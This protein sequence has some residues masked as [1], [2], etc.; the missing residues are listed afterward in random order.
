[1]YCYSL[2]FNSCFYSETKTAV[3]DPDAEGIKY[4]D[5]REDGEN[6]SID[7]DEETK[8]DVDEDSDKDS[9]ED[10]GALHI[11]RVN[12]RSGTRE[13]ERARLRVCVEITHPELKLP[14]YRTWT[15]TAL[16]TPPVVFVSVIKGTVYHAGFGSCCLQTHS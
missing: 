1:M 10:D 15:G 3:T 11:N 14:V 2:H 8:S 7:R 13:N 4:I 9:A 5:E 6:S 12:L 16:Q